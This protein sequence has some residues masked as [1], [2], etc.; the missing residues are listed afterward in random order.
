MATT[1]SNH[2]AF[3]EESRRGADGRAIDLDGV[4]APPQAQASF[5]L[6]KSA[7]EDILRGDVG[8]ADARFDRL[9]PADLE[10]PLAFMRAA[11]AL[12]LGESGAAMGICRTLLE[13]LPED[14]DLAN[15]TAHVHLARGEGE[16]ARARFEKVLQARPH[17]KGA[18]INAFSAPAETGGGTDRPRMVVATSIP[19]RRKAFHGATLGTW[20]ALGFEI[21]SVN[22]ADEIGALAPFFPDV[23]FVPTTA[24]HRSASGNPY[25]RL[26]AIFDALANTGAAVCGIVNADIAFAPCPDL[27]RFLAEYAPDGLVFGSRVDTAEGVVAR[28]DFFDIGFDYFFF[29]QKLLRALPGSEF[30]MGLPWWDYFTPRFALEQGLPTVHNLTP[31]AFHVL[32]PTNWAP[33]AWYEFGLYFARNFIGRDGPSAS[34]FVLSLPGEGR[35]HFLLALSHMTREFIFARSASRLCPVPYM[36]GLSSP[37]SL[38]AM[39][40]D[41]P[42][43]PVRFSPALRVLPELPE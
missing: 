33:R 30:C 2:P 25:V 21:I 41:N 10:P 15:L 4:C 12:S 31:M 42:S 8:G 26:D 18:A 37:F 3:A 17:D 39:V 14:V 27:P 19:P 38:P 40:R 43:T 11:I 20:K 23:T 32:H 28:G 22:P 34:D 1:P 35:K 9:A 13:R 36:A 24:I 29:G 6:W 5:E 16:A 7:R